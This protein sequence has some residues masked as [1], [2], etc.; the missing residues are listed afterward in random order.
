MAATPKP[1]RKKVK[2]HIAH[3]T[4]AVM[5]RS[6]PKAGKESLK[7]VFNKDRIKELKKVYTK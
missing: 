5:K 4:K 7:K 2:Q 1:A 6:L 3:V